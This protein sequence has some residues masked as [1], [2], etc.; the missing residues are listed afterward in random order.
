[1]Y[2][3]YGYY[4]TRYPSNVKLSA[5]QFAVYAEKASAKMDALTNNGIT[6]EIASTEGCKLC[7]CELAEFMAQTAFAEKAS[8]ITSE[9]VGDYSVSYGDSKSR[10]MATAKQ[11][12][13]IVSEW[14]GQWGILYRGVCRHID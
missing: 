13:N 6:N 8:A 1:M 2:A 7:C 3:T 9:R 12:R 4:K 5:T 11:E 10:A 14:L